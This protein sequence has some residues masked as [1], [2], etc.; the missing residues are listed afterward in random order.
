MGTSIV[1]STCRRNLTQTGSRQA[2][3]AVRTWLPPAPRQAP[4]GALAGAFD[5]GA[6]DFVSPQG[7]EALLKR[8][9]MR[10]RFRTAESTDGEVGRIASSDKLPHPAW[11]GGT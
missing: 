3:A 11:T 5:K 10:H 9:A 2:V 4:R 7:C 8:K 6:N 1:W